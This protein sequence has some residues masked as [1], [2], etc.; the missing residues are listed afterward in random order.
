[1]PEPRRREPPTVPPGAEL[2]PGL[3]VVR[4]LR[5]GNDLDVYDAYDEGR[6]CRV[7]VKAPRPDLADDPEVVADLVHEW[8]VLSGIAHPHLVRAYDLRHDAAPGADPPLFV[9]EVLT[10]ETLKALMRRVGR[11][12]LVDVATLGE[13]LTSALRY[14]HDADVLHLDVKPSNIVAMAGTAKLLDL[15]L[16]RPP[17][18]YHPDIGSPG[19]AA[20]EQVVGGELTTAADVWGL[21]LVLHEGATGA[22][23]FDSDDEDAALQVDNRAPRIRTLRRMPRAVADVLDACLEPTPTDRPTLTE[24]SAALAPHADS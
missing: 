11:L 3:R 24:L 10:G 7:T 21:G 6:Y 2:A 17:G 19:Y 13:H 23:P 14:L 12:P 1:M 8:K 22:N 9:M 4:H 20:P 18:R 16:A 5:R 15:S